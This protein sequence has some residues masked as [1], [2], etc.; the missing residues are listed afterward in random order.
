MPGLNLKSLPSKDISKYLFGVSNGSAK[1]ASRVG[2]GQPNPQS[3]LDVS[4]SLI[5]TGNISASGNI[6]GLSLTTPGNITGSTI[7]GQT[8]IAD[9]FLSAPSA[10]ITNLTNT[11]ITSSGNISSS[12]MGTFAQVRIGESTTTNYG[13]IVDYPDTRLLRLKRGGSTKFQVI[14]DNADGQ[15]DI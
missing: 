15:V 1:V 8:L 4:G 14:A 5:V 9:V 11:N 2:I 13:L 10:S 7:E 12:G 6:K 3:E